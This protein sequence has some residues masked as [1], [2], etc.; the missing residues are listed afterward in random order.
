MFFDNHWQV[1]KMESSELSSVGT[2]VTSPKR[3]PS[4]VAVTPKKFRRKKIQCCPIMINKQIQATVA[5]NSKTTDTDIRMKTCSTQVAMNKLSIEIL[6]TSDKLTKDFTGLESY[7]LF[8]ILHKY[9]TAKCDDPECDIAQ[10]KLDP[11]L[12]YSFISTENQL[13][14]TLFK[15]KRNETENIIAYQFGISQSSV[16]D[17][18]NF[19]I[20]LMYRKFKILDICPPLEEM[21]KHMT[22]EFKTQY[23]NVREV[24]D[25]TEIR[26]QRPS[27]PIAQ[28]L[29]YS[30]YKHDHTIKVQIGCDSRGTITSV[31]DTFGGC[32]SDKEIFERSGAKDRL[33]SGEAIMVDKS[34]LVGDILQGTGVQVIRPP[35]LANFPNKQFPA[36]ETLDTRRIARKRII[37]ENVNA[38]LKNYKI[39]SQ[40]VNVKFLRIINEIV[41]VCCSLCNM[42]HPS[43]KK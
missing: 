31:S 6:E 15:L 2:S 14:L 27:D 11:K 10:H 4:S 3:K 5:T 32:A 16:S 35:R 7:D 21:K 18:F 8:K 17:I 20:E 41:Y 25:D 40:R 1:W 33:K 36:E 26:C 9:M 42:G 37:I 12:E 28:K 23:A 29:I 19:W 43:R 13:L 22:E 39:L 24:F 38:K 34:F 30:N